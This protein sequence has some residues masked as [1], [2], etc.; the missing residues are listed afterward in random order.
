[1][2]L[3][4]ALLALLAGCERAATPESAVRTFLRAV[5]RHDCETAWQL[6]SSRTQ[7]AI[8][9]KAA[10]EPAFPGL[11][12]FTPKELYCRPTGAH[13]YRLYEPRTAQ[14]L[15][16]EGDTAL[17]TVKEREGTD[18]LIPGFWPTRFIYHDRQ[19]GLIREDGRWKIDHEVAPVVTR[20]P[21]P[22]ER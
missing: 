13:H 7:R 4:V 2:F 10:A 15:K 5:S 3:V 6:F 14:V 9:Q 20:R 17:V 22:A 1:L 8:E 12:R 16:V 11:V 21:P 19:M 18:F